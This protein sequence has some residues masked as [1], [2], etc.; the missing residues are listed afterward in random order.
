LLGKTRV[1]IFSKNQRDMKIGEFSE[2]EFYFD[3][4]TWPYHVIPE[5]SANWALCSAPDQP[6][7][8]AN[9]ACLDLDEEEKKIKEW[10]K[11]ALYDASPVWGLRNDDIDII[12]RK[13]KLYSSDEDYLKAIDECSKKVDEFADSFECCVCYETAKDCLPRAK[14]FSS[15]KLFVTKCNHI[16]CK[17]CIEQVCDI[18]GVSLKVVKES[19]LG[20][21]FSSERERVEELEDEINERIHD[22]VALRGD[23]GRK[24]GR[25][26]SDALRREVYS[27]RVFDCPMCRSLQVKHG[28][29]IKDL[30]NV[31]EEDI[32]ASICSENKSESRLK[33]TASQQATIIECERLQRALMVNCM[34][35]YWNFEDL[36]GKGGTSGLK[37]FLKHKKKI[38]W[39]FRKT[40]SLCRIMFNR[41]ISPDHCLPGDV[42]EFYIRSIKKIVEWH[43]ERS[44][45]PPVSTLDL[46]DI[47][48]GLQK[49]ILRIIDK[50]TSLQCTY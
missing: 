9:H 46:D 6:I 42:W 33:L 8:D 48:L 35:F 5:Q 19:D 3:D 32:Y 10:K 7:S 47:P 50:H 23:T 43:H 18:K 30:A 13:K 16:I 36:G 41:N 27:R 22:W 15:S 26:I 49:K 29:L 39:F 12:S 31:I 40:S 1:M 45:F 25:R 20:P 24:W 4:A 37:F 34:D 11:V 38:N 44:N 17:E 2:W 28:L 21:W 14:V